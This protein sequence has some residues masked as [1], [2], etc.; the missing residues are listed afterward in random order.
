MTGK[1]FS[2]RNSKLPFA[3]MWPLGYAIGIA[4]LASKVVLVKQWP[5]ADFA[6]SKRWGEASEKEDSTKRCWKTGVFH[7]KNLIGFKVNCFR[8]TEC[9]G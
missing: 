3:C 2:A 5:K 7:L 8:L 6:L 4:F 1:T 9:Q